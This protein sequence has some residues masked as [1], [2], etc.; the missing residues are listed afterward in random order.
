MIKKFTDFI[1][2][3]KLKEEFSQAEQII[4]KKD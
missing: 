4:T 3:R 1:T 2:R